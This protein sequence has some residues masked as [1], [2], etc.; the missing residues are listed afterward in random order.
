MYCK[1]PILY[2]AEYLKVCEVLNEQYFDIQSYSRFYISP[3][4]VIGWNS[5]RNLHISH[6][7]N[8]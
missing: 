4:L 1:F 3:K 2:L 7:A 8:I 6:Q 5:F